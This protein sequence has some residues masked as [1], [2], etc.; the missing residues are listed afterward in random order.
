MSRRTGERESWLCGLKAS[1]GTHTWG[2]GA[3]WDGDG[4]RVDEGD[5]DACTHHAC[6]HTKG[7]P[8]ML[9]KDNARIQMQQGEEVGQSDEGHV[10]ASCWDLVLGRCLVQ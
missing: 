6:V 7:S 1:A 3:S 4:A 10:L 5:G 2:H 9:L 8:E